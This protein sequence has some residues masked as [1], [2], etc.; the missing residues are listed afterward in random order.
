MTPSPEL[1]PDHI[2]GR[3]VFSPLRYPCTVF[4]GISKSG[5]QT[6]S[7]PEFFRLLYATAQIAFITT[8]IIVSLE[9]HIRS[10]IYD[11]FHISFR[12]LI[13]SWREDMNP[14]MTSSQH[15]W[16]HSVN[17][18][19]SSRVQTPLKF[20]IFQASL[21]SYLNCLHN[22]EDHSLT[23]FTQMISTREELSY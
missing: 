2:G 3:R 6:P 17:G 22:W 23:W 1:N 19:A 16:L 21:Q 12:L 15:Q 8:R 7:S 5:V 10:S 14:Q 9:L 11:S 4:N 20:W 13:H 18:I